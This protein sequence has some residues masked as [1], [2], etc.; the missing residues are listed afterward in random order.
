MIIPQRPSPT[1]CH[2]TGKQSP[3]WAYAGCLPLEW[4]DWFNSRR[5]LEPIGNIPPAE[6]EQRDHD[7]MSAQ[8]LAA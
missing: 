1:S 2:G 7:T 8:K 6:A 4:G 5:L 3:E